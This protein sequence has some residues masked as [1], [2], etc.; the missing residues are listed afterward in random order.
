MSVLLRIYRET[1][2][3]PLMLSLTDTLKG[4][5]KLKGNIIIGIT[6]CSD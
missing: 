1:S 4:F 6:E 5:I 3:Y 2:A